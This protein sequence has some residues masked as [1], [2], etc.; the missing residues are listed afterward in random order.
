MLTTPHRYGSD[1]F[2]AVYD[3]K[4]SVKLDSTWR[5]LINYRAKNGQIEEDFFFDHWDESIVQRIMDESAKLTDYHKKHSHPHATSVCLV[6]DDMAD[7]Q[8]ILHATGNSLLNTL[9]IRGR[10]YDLSA[11]VA[12]Q[13]P[14]LTSNRLRTQAS[15]L[16]IFKQRNYKDLDLLLTELSGWVPRSVLRD[17]YDICTREKYQFMMINL[18]GKDMDHMFYWSLDKTMIVSRM[19]ED[20]E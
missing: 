14:S 3:I 18:L 7:Q 10:H 9:F 20:E 1:V 6:V 11:I 12:T 16:Y 17:M 4:P 5:H 13:R 15:A 2:D 8:H 19:L